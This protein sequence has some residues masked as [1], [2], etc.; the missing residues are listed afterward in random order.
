MIRVMKTSILLIFFC[1]LYLHAQSLQEYHNLVEKNIAS[2]NYNQALI[3]AQDAV[4]FARNNFG[5]E[6]TA[7]AGARLDLGSVFYEM[8]R[9][10]EAEKCFLDAMN[11][12]KEFFGEAHPLF[13]KALNGLA[14]AYTKLGRFEEAK[15]FYLKALDIKESQ[16]GKNHPS[17]AVSL[18]N[19]GWLYESMGNYRDAELAY[20]ESLKIW[21]QTEGTDNPGYALRLNN[22]GV[23]FH[24]MG[25]YKEAEKYYRQSIDATKA[26]LGENHPQYAKGLTSLARLFHHMGMYEQSEHLYKDVLKKLKVALGINHPTYA[27]TESSLADLYSDMGVY[28]EAEEIY[29]RSIEIIKSQLGEEHPRYASEL[30]D[31]AGLYEK[32]ERFIEAEQLYLQSQELIKNNF[33]TDHPFF[34][35]N[36]NNLAGLYVKMENYV[37]AEPLYKHSVTIMANMFGK[38]HPQYATSLLNLAGLYRMM[39]KY[40]ES[41]GV[42][43]EAL[44]IIKKHYGENHPDYAIGLSGMAMLLTKMDRTA[45]AEF[46][47]NKLLQNYRNQI[48]NYFP[49]MSEKE[50][51]QFYNTIK[52]HYNV[53]YIFATRRMKDNPSILGDMYNV[54]LFTKA[55]LFNTSLQVRENILKSNDYE[56]V[57][58][59]ENWIELRE[60]LSHIYSLP[61]EKRE[62][63]QVNVDY[64]TQK[65]NNLEKEL[66]KYSLQFAGQHDWKNATWQKVQEALQ[67]D[68]A[69]IE[70]IRFTNEDSTYYAALILK[71]ESYSNPELVI[72]PN[73]NEMEL[74][75][76][77]SY[78][79]YIQEGSNVYDE[80]YNIYWKR[81]Y[82]KIY[83]KRRV[84]LSL[85]GIFNQIN[86][87]SLRNPET[88]NY[89]LDEME[90]HTVSNTKDLIHGR[91]SVREVRT[92]ALFGR[93]DYQYN[94]GGYNSG[95]N[96]SNTHGN[97]RGIVLTKKK[98][99]SIN[100]FT[101]TDLPLT[102]VEVDKI[103]ALLNQ[104]GWI[105]QNFSGTEASEDKIKRMN[106]PQVLHIATHGY[107]EKDDHKDNKNK[108]NP[109]LRSYL[110]FTGSAAILNQ[111]TR[112]EYGIED[113]ILTAYEAMN[114]NLSS[115]ELVVL[116][117]CQTGLGDVVS[118]EGVY[119]LQRAF[120]QAGASNVLM[121]LWEVDDIA[122]QELMLAFYEIW[123]SGAS[124]ENALREAMKTIRQKYKHPYFWAPF[125]LIG[126]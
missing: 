89:V 73:G 14:S 54:R 34:A 81:I 31:L 25:R 72:F 16:I 51:T 104:Y 59:Y 110:F 65:A 85:D 7:Y 106:A 76:S 94:P 95:N 68:E 84:Y 55:L 6:D 45:E 11:I 69:A 26:M 29:N 88:G 115:T 100:K 27:I 126:H 91:S 83:D 111:S 58:K 20:T 98:K 87:Y 118:G 92:A 36:I 75:Y 74:D 103:G 78:Q 53:Y 90:I 116:S 82:D 22:L 60:Y 19:L 44:E 41:E 47:F 86:L 52:E 15:R 32:T 49:A 42:Y 17:Y 96:T 43:L 66:S 114:L 125:V 97:T 37:G 56:L 123:L 109:L 70:I 71:S 3:Y 119:G 107:F 67:P 33:G 1:S 38:D 108:E 63:V 61:I 80:L 35:T 64:L 24:G 50:R 112:P 113:G 2:A 117:A 101:L 39:E 48:D 105:T 62:Q 4:N 30:N 13:V 77:I 12:Y 18:N 124:K 21:E 5:N 121:S 99:A 28:D 57:K 9:H 79:S 120:Q 93:P 122:T 23:L 8:G 40:R 10:Q 102:E 46:Y